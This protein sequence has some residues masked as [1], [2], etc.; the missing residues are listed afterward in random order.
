M[1]AALFNF[2]ILIALSTPADFYLCFPYL[3]FPPLRILLA[4][5]VLAFSTPAD[6]T[7]VFL[8]YIFQPPV[9]PFSVL[10]FSVAPFY[11]PVFRILISNEMELFKY[12]NFFLMAT[13]GHTH[14]DSISCNLFFWHL[15]LMMRLAAIFTYFS[16]MKF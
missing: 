13:F 7:C 10:A 12:W 5:S 11:P 9:L 2:S 6:V 14:F 4:F 3:H 1:L 8:T 16:T 15:I